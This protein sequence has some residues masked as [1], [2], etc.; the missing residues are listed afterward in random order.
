M[1]NTLQDSLLDEA[2]HRAEQSRHSYNVQT[3]EFRHLNANLQSYLDEIKT[4]DE[5]NRRIQESIEAI[6][7]SYVTTLEHHLIRLP[8]NFRQQSQTLTQA[9]VERYKS[10]SRARRLTSERE[11]LKRRIH[12]VARNEKD[13]H[14]QLTVLH[15]QERLVQNEF[16]QLSSHIESLLRSVENE[17]QLH[18]QAMSKVDHLQLQ[19]EQVCVER[20]KTEVME[21]VVS[22]L[23]L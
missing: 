16:R 17:K 20:S 23:H 3:E 21:S 9:H 14:K 6:R 12:F 10:K 18:R 2:V 22:F 4:I 15:K 19:L 7:A 5:E 11:E 13:Q 1:I 8:N